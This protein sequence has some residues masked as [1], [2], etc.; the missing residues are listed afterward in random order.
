MTD[1]KLLEA[2]SAVLCGDLGQVLMNGIKNLPE[3]EE[4]SEDMKAWDTLVRR[5]EALAS[6]VGFLSMTQDDREQVMKEN[7]PECTAVHSGGAYF[8]W[9]WKGCGFGQM[10]FDYDSEKKEWTGDTEC[11]GPE[12]TR[13]LLHAF[14]D[15][16]ADNLAPLI[17]KEREARRAGQSE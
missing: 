13:K 16:V 17:I 1:Q 15:H 12:S 6:P 4:L 14:A 3:G 7:P 10:S 8:D 5:F 2:L 11:M 9:S